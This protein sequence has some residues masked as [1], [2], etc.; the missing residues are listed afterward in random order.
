MSLSEDLQQIETRLPEEIAQIDTSA[1]VVEKLVSFLIQAEDHRFLRHSGVDIIAICRAVYKNLFTSSREG[2]STIEQQLVRVI[3]GHYE[4]TF[5]RKI[6]EIYL[7]RKLHRLADKKT[8]AYTYLNIAYYGTAYQ[9]L[10]AILH[11]F[12]LTKEDD[13]PDEICAEIVARLK[14]PEPLSRSAY[15]QERIRRRV[16]YILRRVRRNVNQ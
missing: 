6:K 8:I 14:Y 11:R 12:G 2:A 4:H 10:D 9:N 15:Q 7:A 16:V 3:T 5:S 13:V 1:P